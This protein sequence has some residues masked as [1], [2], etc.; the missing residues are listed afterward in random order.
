[1]SRDN[2]YY[3]FYKNAPVKQ[4]SYVWGFGKSANHK[5]IFPKS[6]IKK[7]NQSSL[8]NIH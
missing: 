8:V 2:A 1:M 6:L 4:E 7:A 3:Q 5:L